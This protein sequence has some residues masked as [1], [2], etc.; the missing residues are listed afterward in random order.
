MLFILKNEKGEETPILKNSN[1]FEHITY[2]W[3]N[4]VAKAKAENIFIIGKASIGIELT[5]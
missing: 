2:V 4:F 3:D 1:A 5:V